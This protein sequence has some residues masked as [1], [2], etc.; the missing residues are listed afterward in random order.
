MV[1]PPPAKNGETRYST[2][3]PFNNVA[4]YNGFSMPAGICDITAGGPSPNNCRT[5]LTGLGTYTA[6]IVVTQ[7]N[8]ASGGDQIA[9]PEALNI[10]VTVT[11][12]GNVSITLEGY[13]TRYAP[14]TTP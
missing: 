2:T 10:A 8:L 3:F 13:R 7:V 14:N 5:P 1:L 6:S 12:P 4:D 11:G 9:S